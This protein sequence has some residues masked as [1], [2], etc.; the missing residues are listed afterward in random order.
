MLEIIRD[1]FGNII[2][3]CEYRLLNQQGRYDK[4]GKYIWIHEV[5][6]S[7]SYRNNGIIKKLIKNISDKVP[8]FEYCYFARYKRNKKVRCYS[9]KNWL[10]RI[11]EKKYAMA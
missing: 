9:R 10:N 11:K 5:E 7:K 3:A 4:N 6:I 8:D 1:D 2:C